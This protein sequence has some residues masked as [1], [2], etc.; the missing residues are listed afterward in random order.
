MSPPAPTSIAVRLHLSLYAS[1]S[2]SFHPL[3]FSEVSLSQPLFFEDLGLNGYLYQAQHPSCHCSVRLNPHFV[4]FNSIFRG[5]SGPKRYFSRMQRSEDVPAPQ[6][7]SCHCFFHLNP[8]NATLASFS[9]PSCQVARYL[10]VPLNFSRAF[11]VNVQSA[12]PSSRFRSPNALIENPY[13][14]PLPHAHVH[15]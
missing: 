10:D 7:S 4:S 5:W 2:M 3:P 1:I 15:I 6:H 9:V 8:L 13:M 11:Q 12:P 14:P